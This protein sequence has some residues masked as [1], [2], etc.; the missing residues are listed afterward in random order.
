VKLFGRA[1]IVASTKEWHEPDLANTIELFGDSNSWS[2]QREAS[3]E[4]A[5]KGPSKPPEMKD[6]LE[7]IRTFHEIR[8]MKRM[9]PKQA[10]IF[11]DRLN[12]LAIAHK[13]SQEDFGEVFPPIDLR[14]LAGTPAEN[15]PAAFCAL[16]E[17]SRIRAQQKVVQG[18]HDVRHAIANTREADQKSRVRLNQRGRNDKLAEQT[19]R[20]IF[21]YEAAKPKTNPSPSKES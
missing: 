16:L 13:L 12:E 4:Q 9:T 2:A 17:P 8:Q 10:A 19:A 11:A 1:L 18:V 3:I 7:F 5:S 6:Y 21:S 15:L 20:T 14:K